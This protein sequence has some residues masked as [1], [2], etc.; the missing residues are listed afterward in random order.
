M[1]DPISISAAAPADLPVLGD[2][3]YSS[4]LA[5]S[6][7]RLLIKD[8]PNEENQRRNY[9]SSI[10]SSLSDSSMECLKA[11]DNTSGNIVGFVVLGKSSALTKPPGDDELSK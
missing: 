8:W 6:I 5:L 11:V 7:N 10:E 2:F 9:S 3:L 4:K 1:T